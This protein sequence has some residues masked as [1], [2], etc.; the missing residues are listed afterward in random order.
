MHSSA[1]IANYTDQRNET[2]ASAINNFFANDTCWNCVVTVA[3]IAMD[4]S[5]IHNVGE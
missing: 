5:I 2:A 1:H 3:C 4:Q